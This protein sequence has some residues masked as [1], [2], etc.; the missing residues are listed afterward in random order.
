MTLELLINDEEQA[1]I[2]DAFNRGPSVVARLPR[3]LM[4]R[5]YVEH[6]NL[7]ALARQAGVSI[8]KPEG[9]TTI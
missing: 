6:N 5:W 7:M 3:D 2:D 1:M 8:T 4:H 9:R